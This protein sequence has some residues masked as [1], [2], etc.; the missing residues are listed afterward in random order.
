MFPIHVF[1]GKEPVG[2]VCPACKEKNDR[3]LT[4]LS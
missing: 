4:G 1:L 3:E 2:L